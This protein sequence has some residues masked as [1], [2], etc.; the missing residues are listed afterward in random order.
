MWTLV[1]VNAELNWWM[2]R[3]REIMAKK[4]AVPANVEA[5]RAEQLAAGAFRAALT[6]VLVVA[7]K[8]LE[9]VRV[10]AMTHAAVQFDELAN[11]YDA[12]NVKRMQCEEASRRAEAEA[13]TQLGHVTG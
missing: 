1:T 5:A 11:R 9:A 4:K 8:A 2:E 7:R 6:D 10:A 12:G 3:K 13:L